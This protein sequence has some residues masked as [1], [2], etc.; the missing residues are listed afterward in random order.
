MRGRPVLVD[1]DQSR[2]VTVREKFASWVGER[3]KIPGARITLA[4]ETTGQ[5][6]VIWSQEN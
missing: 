6:L 2:E 3:R 5:E 4:D 1:C